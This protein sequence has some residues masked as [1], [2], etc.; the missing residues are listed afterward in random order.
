MMRRLEWWLRERA[1]VCAPKALYAILVRRSWVH[2]PELAV[3]ASRA[4]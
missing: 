1:Q 2:K 3:L 4:G